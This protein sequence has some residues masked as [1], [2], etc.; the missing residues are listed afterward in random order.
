MFGE[1]LI[2]GYKEVSLDEKGRIFLPKF[3][4]VEKGDKISVIENETGSFKLFNLMY[5]QRIIDELNKKCC[6][7]DQER[8]QLLSDRLQL[9]YYSYLTTCNVDSQRRIHIP[10]QIL[11]EH[12]FS[13]K[14][15]MQGSGTSL[16]VFNSK[17]SYNSYVRKLRATK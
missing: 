2:L 14:V 13:D 5:M 8:I 9:L 17:E 3:T 1:D 15:I 16:T 6:S 10:Q 7:K 4:G 12:E 11:D